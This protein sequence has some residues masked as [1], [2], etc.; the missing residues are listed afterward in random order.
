MPEVTDLSPVVGINDIDIAITVTGANFNEGLSRVTLASADGT[1]V[2]DLGG[3][4]WISSGK[5]TATVPSGCN[6]GQYNIQ[7]YNPDGTYNL[8]SAV[9]LE[10]CGSV[11]LSVTTSPTT[12]SN[13]AR[14]PDNAT[15]PVELTLCTDDREEVDPVKATPMRIAVT[16]DP[17]TEIEK[18]QQ[19]GTSW[20]DYTGVINP[21]RQVRPTEGIVE[22]LGGN[23]VAFTMG[24]E[25]KLRFKSGRVMV[26]R[27]D[28]TLPSTSAVPTIYY[29]EADGTLTLAGVDGEK[30]GQA[31]A[32]GGTVLATRPGVPATG[33]TTYTFGLLLDHMSTFAAGT[34]GAPVPPA[35]SGGDGGGGCFID[36]LWEEIR[37]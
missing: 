27:V 26:A 19:G 6:Q 7:V 32:M 34:I 22:E 2:K 1:I 3:V 30:G 17:G 23:A 28:I 16:I 29:L 24:A 25:T 4:G 18:E 13:A 36:T 9:K 35:P 14:M 37:N 21:P 5:L 8:V 12:T 10:V 31:Y 20:D 33:Y 11:E 15:V